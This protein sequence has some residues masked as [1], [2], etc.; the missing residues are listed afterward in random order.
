MAQPEEMQDKHQPQHPKTR[1]PRNSGGASV[2]KFCCGST[3]IGSLFQSRPNSTQPVWATPACCP[4]AKAHPVN[5]RSPPTSNTDLVETSPTQHESNFCAF[6]VSPR[7]MQLNSLQIWT[8][9]SDGDLHLAARMLLVV[10][11]SWFSSRRFAPLWAATKKQVCPFEHQ[12]WF[13]RQTR[14]VEK[15][16]STAFSDCDEHIF[17]AAQALDAPIA[18]KQSYGV[19]VLVRSRKGSCRSSRVQRRWAIMFLLLK[20]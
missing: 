6:L 3:P 10:F 8:K 5:L 7:I 16:M 2:G 11:F 13:D 15:T 14:R 1:P 9:I 19:V 17:S 18:F 12:S 20:I 4:T